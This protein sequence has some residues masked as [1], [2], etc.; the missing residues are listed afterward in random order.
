MK[1]VVV[2]D[3]G[4]LRNKMHLPCI[5]TQSHKKNSTSR[6]VGRDTSGIN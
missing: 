4:A 2:F 5:H 6:Y 1:L 3:R